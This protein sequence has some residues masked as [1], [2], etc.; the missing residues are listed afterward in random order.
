MYQIYYTI[1]V[2]EARFL[3]HPRVHIVLEVSI[4]EWQTDAVEAK[5]G[6]ELGVP[7]HE[8]VFEELIEEELL[9][10]FSEN[11]QHGSSML[12]FVPRITSTGGNQ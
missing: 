3:Q 9:L 11:L 4:V 8:E 1:K 7:L 6:K 10:L 5:A 12:M 2:F